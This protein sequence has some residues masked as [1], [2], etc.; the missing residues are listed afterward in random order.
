MKKRKLL[1]KAKSRAPEGP[2]K[3]V[4][5]C[6]PADSWSDP[7]KCKRAQIDIKSRL[8]FRKDE[9]GGLLGPLGLLGTQKFSGC[10]RFL[11]PRDSQGFLYP[12]TPLPPIVPGPLEVAGSSSITG[13]NG[14]RRPP[15]VPRSIV[16]NELHRAP[17]SVQGP[18][19]SRGPKATRRL[20]APGPTRIPGPP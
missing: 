7:G 15:G 3:V 14:F 2:W 19:V 20:L 1:R 12:F 13:L 5:G 4:Y 17:W 11:G 18:W 16:D 9:N 8:C 6:V 10:Q